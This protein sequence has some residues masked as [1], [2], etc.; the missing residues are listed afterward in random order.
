MTKLTCYSLGPESWRLVV[1]I[2][3]TELASI[4]IVFAAGMSHFISGRLNWQKKVFNLLCFVQ[5]E[6]RTS[7][8]DTGM[9]L[10]NGGYR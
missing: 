2:W 10:H 8:C 4:C 6:T 5:V 3:L 1:N 9:I 7:G